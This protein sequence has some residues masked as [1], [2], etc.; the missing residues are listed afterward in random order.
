M[1]PNPPRPGPHRYAWGPFPWYIVFRDGGHTRR[2]FKTKREA[3]EWYR[4]WRLKQKMAHRKNP[5][6]VKLGSR[7]GKAR[8]AKLSPAQRQEIARKAGIASGKA[9]AY[10]P[11]IGPKD[12]MAAS[13]GY[14]DGK[15]VDPRGARSKRLEHAESG[16]LFG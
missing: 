6:A 13:L 15:A 10:A 16:D 1:T 11:G 8:K 9:R 14:V 2:R 4:S 7:G 5:E 3:A 12:L